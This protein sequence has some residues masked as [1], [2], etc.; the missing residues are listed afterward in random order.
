MAE[1]EAN[2]EPVGETSENWTGNVDVSPPVTEEIPETFI[3]AETGSVAPAL[4]VQPQIPEAPPAAEEAS[5][6][7]WP[8]PARPPEEVSA[9]VISDEV[10]TEPPAVETEVPEAPVDMGERGPANWNLPASAIEDISA[11]I[12]SDDQRGHGPA[13]AVESEISDA[14]LVGNDLSSGAW[15]V[16]AAAAPPAAPQA[17]VRRP[18]PPA[19]QAPF[20]SLGGLGFIGGMTVTRDHF[21]GGMPIKLPPLPPTPFGFG[22]VRIDTSVRP[23]AAAAP[24]PSVAPTPPPPVIPA[25]APQVSAPTP[26]PPVIPAADPQVSAPTP[27]PPPVKPRVQSPPSQSKPPPVSFIPRP[28]RKSTFATDVYH[29]PEDLPGVPRPA[30]SPG[31]SAFEGLAMGA[32]VFSASGANPLPINDAPF[33]GASMNRPYDFGIPE[34]AERADRAAENPEEDFAEDDFWNRTDEEDGAAPATK[35]V[36]RRPGPPQ[37]VVRPEDSNK[38][39]QKLVRP[40]DSNEPPQNLVRPEASNEPLQNLVRP[41]DSNEPLQNLVRPEDSNEP[42]ENP[43]TDLHAD[44]SDDSSDE[45]PTDSLGDALEEQPVEAQLAA[46]AAATP[47]RETPRAAKRR[48]FRIPFLMPIIL[49]G[50]GVALAAI[51]RFVPVRS[52]S[53][54]TLTFVNFNYIP[55]TQDSI[56]FEAAQRRFLDDQTR[57]NALEIMGRDNPGVAA[58]FLKSPALF[59]RVAATVSFS[60]PAQSGSPQTLLQMSS[61]GGDKEG[62]L[63][64]MLALLQ[65]LADRNAPQADSNRQ[66]RQELQSAQQTVD[67]AQQKVDSIK[68][69]LSDLM[70]AIEAAPPADQ[71]AQ[72]ATKKSVLEQDRLDAAAALNRDRADLVRPA[73]PTDTTTQPA[74]ADPQLRQM[75]Q[76]L[77]DLSAEMDSSRSDQLQE[78]AQAR[79][80]LEDAARQFDEQI[81]AANTLLDGGSQLRQFVDSAMDSQSKARDLIDTLIVDGEDLEQQLEDTRRDVDDLIQS[82]QA[83]KWAIDPQLQSLRENLESAQHRYNANAGQGITDARILDPLQKEID[84]WTAQ[85]KAR[86]AELGADPGEIRVEASL[87]NIIDALRKKLAK[88]KHQT[89]EILDPLQKQLANLDPAAAALPAAEQDLARRIHQRLDALNDARQKFAE[90]FG[91]N[92]IAPS[93]KV[94]E[95]QKRIAGLKA[96]IAARQADMERAA[97]AAREAWEHYDPAEA[98]ARVRTDQENFDATSKALEAEMSAFDDAH[99]K[100][101]AADAAQQKKVNL[102]DD[103]QSAEAALETARKD[104]DEKQSAAD[105]AFEIKPVTSADVATIA[106]ADP[107]MMYS[108]A[109]MAGGLIAVALV[110]FASHGGHRGLPKESEAGPDMD[111]DFDSLDLGSDDDHPATA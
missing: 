107:R 41:E 54:G 61:T 108:A 49:L 16:P 38:P 109:V 104:R 26:P 59:D 89:D 90:T 84:D 44:S 95:L 58:G 31:P 29:P 102:L 15:T 57:E 50:I 14:P 68:S 24:P 46:A 77:A 45:S 11:P 37:Y 65:S 5:V 35:P 98:Q 19:F 82:Q 33:G 67:D 74:V 81:V 85:V 7:V 51:W 69:Q 100:Q 92:A 55:G 110:A 53:V 21:L 64:R 27:P 94:M 39:P 17:D 70:P 52:Q 88:E 1:A 48:R 12:I 106:P 23:A 60:S 76:Q 97:A 83:E 79:G 10:S 71:L 103:Q 30:K 22:Q 66:L 91:E 78:A 47:V 18:A 40:E 4:S 6:D 99:A 96:D 13:R 3:T 32:D 8:T 42:P 86:Q 36:I 28:P 62:D 93:A 75:R 2:V 105:H 80:N 34:S 87:N 73:A 63:A 20:S 9:P 56:D 111:A 72:L 25:A 101:V 43:P